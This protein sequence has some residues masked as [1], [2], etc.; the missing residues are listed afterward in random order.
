MSVSTNM[1]FR[2][3]ADLKKEA[4]DLFSDLGITMTNAM[5]MFLKQSVRTQGIPFE[6]TRIPNAET[7]A[8]MEEAE[9]IAKDRNVQGYNDLSS[10]FEDLKTL[11]IMT[12]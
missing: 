1:S 7:L 2:V 8:A 9:R 11:Q 12:S 3:D 4:E 10:L 5:T 6:V